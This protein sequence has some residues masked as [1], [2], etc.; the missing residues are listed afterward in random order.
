MDLSY[1]VQEILHFET[2][3]L[4]KKF[5]NTSIRGIELLVP[6]TKIQ[7]NYNVLTPFYSFLEKFVSTSLLHSLYY[8]IKNSLNGGDYN[9]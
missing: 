1:V 8:E 5:K 2:W 4:L 9:K 6:P 7:K 3:K